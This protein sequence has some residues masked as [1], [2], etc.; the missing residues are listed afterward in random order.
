MNHKKLLII[1]LSFYVL[2]AFAGYL[3]GLFIDVTRDAGKYATISKEIFENGNF[4]NLTVH[5]E[6]YDQKPPLL[7]WLGAAGFYVGNI[8]NFWFKFPVF[9]LVLFGFYGAYKLGESLYN[10]Q[11]GILTAGLMFTSCIY[12]LY[13]M[14]IHTDTLLQ[15]FITLSIWQLFEFVKT[16]KNKNFIF[17]FISVGLAMLTKGPIGAAIPAFAVGGHILLKKDF[18]KLLDVRW[19]LGIIISFVVVSPAILGLSNQFG[20]EGIRF[21]FWENMAGRYTGTYVANAV[22]DPFFYIHNLLYLLLPWSL[23]FFFAVYLEFQQLFKIKFKAAEF[24]TFTGIWIYFLI[25]SSSESQLPNYVFP[26]IP[27]M[28]VLIAKWVVIISEE[29]NL[30][31]KI[32]FTIQN[33]VVS[34]IWIAVFVLAVYLFPGVKFY[35]WV[36]VL[37]GGI[38]SWYILKNTNTLWI[39]LF[40]PSAIAIIS[41][42]FLLNTHIFPYIFSFQ[43]PPKAARY[44]TE[45]SAENDKL[46]NYRYTQYELFFYSNPQ[47]LQLCSADDVKIAASQKG[48]WIFTDKE[49]LEEIQKL[50]LNP[51]VIE[52][53]HL[54]LNKGAKFILPKKRQSALFPMYLVHFQ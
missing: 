18:R 50:N 53:Q 1:I 19:V 17:G 40:T 22:N 45:N 51:E 47:A 52:Y 9:L 43:A 6:A 23:L 10:R 49:G 15:V 44:F 31:W 14:D 41:L 13:S 2:L 46:Y 7:F 24:L 16:G 5:G 25:I 29:Y 54:F 26:V 28:S 48:S 34:L 21:F 20:W 3:S 36:I 8:S 38:S 42:F 39:K 12:S 33:I 27:L 4:I 35:Y 11:T 30:R 37:I 32:A